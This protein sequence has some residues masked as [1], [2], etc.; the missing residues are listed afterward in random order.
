M[1]KVM[2]WLANRQEAALGI[3]ADKY[4]AYMVLLAENTQGEL[5][6]LWQDMVE[7]ADRKDEMDAAASLNVSD[8]NELLELAVMRARQNC[9][10]NI[11]CNLALDESE[12][13]YYEKF[14]PEMSCQELEQAIRLDF[15][16]A[17][18]WQEKYY[19]SY[20]AMG[21][22]MMRIGGIQKK[23]LEQ[24]LLA[25]RQEYA[26]S[27]AVLVC[28]GSLSEDIVQGLYSQGAK[29]AAGEGDEGQ[30]GR[31]KLQA[32]IYAA[33]CGLR[34]QGI[35]FR[36]YKEYLSKWNWLHAAQA[37]WGTAMI[38]LA[39]LWGMG[40][41]MQQDLDGQLGKVE[42]QLQLMEDI[43]DRERQIEADREIMGK[44]NKLLA[45]LEQSSQPGQGI[46]ARLGRG[47][48][49]GIWLTEVKRLED[50]TVSLRGRAAL[51]GGISALLDDLNGNSARKENPMTLETADMAQDGRIDFQISGR[52]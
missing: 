46:L 25:L 12:V 16:A 39:M 50:G 47:F 51:Y 33:L 24:R 2:Q 34:N 37:M 9:P 13:F 27:Q 52:L 15:A 7:L 28:Q 36:P 17:S 10:E 40:W 3:A 43:A 20:Q 6:L 49:E 38:V 11:T 18:A 22:G 31:E 26:W 45:D 1:N 29:A 30:E 23:G 41:Y 48:Q 4:V 14:F 42:S 35:V 32:A 19:C 5:E 21:Q 44:K 8:N